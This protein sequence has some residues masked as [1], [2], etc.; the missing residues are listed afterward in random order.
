MACRHVA[1]RV[2]AGSSTDNR[3]TVGMRKIRD[4]CTLVILL[5][6]NRTHQ[7]ADPRDRKRVENYGT[8]PLHFDNRSLRC[9]KDILWQDR[10]VTDDVSRISHVRVI[11][12]TAFFF[13]AIT[14]RRWSSAAREFKCNF[15]S[16]SLPVPYYAH[17]TEQMNII[18]N[19]IL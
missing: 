10:V 4:V 9:I 8:S 14:S 15:L 17:I 3:V 6:G 11:D 1:A 7:M 18:Y 13:Y 19:N 16:L 5:N 12:C 2:K